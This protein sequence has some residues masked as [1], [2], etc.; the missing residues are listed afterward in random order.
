ML[1]RKVGEKLPSTE[2]V[3]AKMFVSFFDEFVNSPLF[4]SKHM[5]NLF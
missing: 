3:T 2:A 4:D 1:T 5:I